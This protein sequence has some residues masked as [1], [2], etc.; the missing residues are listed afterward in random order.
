MGRTRGKPPRGLIIRTVLKKVYTAGSYFS[1]T[2]GGEVEKTALVIFDKIIE[3][4]GEVFF[5]RGKK[6]FVVFFPEEG[7]FKT[8]RFICKPIGGGVHPPY[9]D[10]RRVC[11]LE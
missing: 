9:W 11:P 10:A 2:T 7:L 3:Y 8:A 4:R 5:S 6:P 1:D